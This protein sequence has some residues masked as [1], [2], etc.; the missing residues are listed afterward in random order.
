[1]V[2]ILQSGLNYNFHLMIKHLA[3]IKKYIFSAVLNKHNVET[4]KAI[5]Y[6]LK[7]FDSCRFLGSYFLN[8]W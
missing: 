4:K 2:V 1:M 6:D 3:K 8:Y 7:Y 5:K